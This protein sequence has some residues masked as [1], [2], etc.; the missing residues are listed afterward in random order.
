[1]P[2]CL[3]NQP[4][5]LLKI[6]EPQFVRVCKSPGNPQKQTTKHNNKKIRMKIQLKC[7]PLEYRRGTLKNGGA[8]KGPEMFSRTN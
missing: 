7:S 5:I 8:G 3:S 6:S 4:Q 1:L 2:V